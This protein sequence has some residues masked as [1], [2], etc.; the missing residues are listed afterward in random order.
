M[1]IWEPTEA[2]LDGFVC[3]AGTGGRRPGQSGRPGAL[4][5]GHTIMTVLADAGTRYRAKLVKP[6]FL[7]G[8][9]CRCRTG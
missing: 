7:R 5:P 3:S 6:P 9:A 1:E 4:G 2:R 8:K